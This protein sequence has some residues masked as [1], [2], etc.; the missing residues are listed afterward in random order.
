MY[1]LVVAE[2]SNPTDGKFVEIV[3]NYNSIAQD[4]PLAIE[5]ERVEYWLSKGAQP[6]NTVARLLNS[7]A[8]FSLPVETKNRPPKKQAKEEPKADAKPAE[9]SA[10]AAPAAE[11]PTDTDKP[12]EEAPVEEPAPEA[13]PAEETPAEAASDEEPPAE[14]ASDTDSGEEPTPD[15]PKE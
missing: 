8:G 4:Q 13:A 6:S 3:G 12:A 14:P 5:K 11:A 9:A 1:R 15:E 2:N 7:K 10:E